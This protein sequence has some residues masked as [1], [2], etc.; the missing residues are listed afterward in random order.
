MTPEPKITVETDHRYDVVIYERKTC[1]VDTVAGENMQ[2]NTGYY[3]AEKRLETAL[4]RLNEH[5]SAAIVPAGR[6]PKGSK[7]NAKDIQ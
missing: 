6:Y 3:N 5:Y 7:L 1:I 2:L 4:G